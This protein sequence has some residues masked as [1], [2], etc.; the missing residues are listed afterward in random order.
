M[1]ALMSILGH[2]ST[3]FEEVADK[4]I[5][6]CRLSLASQISVYTPRYPEIEVDKISVGF[7]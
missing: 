3:Y 5:G 4:T 1:S 7:K 2:G 6:S